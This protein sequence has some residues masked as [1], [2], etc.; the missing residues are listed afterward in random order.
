MCAKRTCTVVVTKPAILRSKI[1][2]PGYTHRNCLW[3][4][5]W[6]VSEP[7]QQNR[8]AQVL[9]RGIARGNSSGLFLSRRAAAQGGWSRFC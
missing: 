8:A 2:P 1:A 3:H 4:F 6:P 7:P 9:R 5:L